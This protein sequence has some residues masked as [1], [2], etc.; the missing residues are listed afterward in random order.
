MSLR[1]RFV[2]GLVGI[3]MAWAV[4]AEALAAMQRI[5]LSP[6]RYSVSRGQPIRVPGRCLDLSRP[7]PQFHHT[8][9]GG[10][11]SISVTRT[12]NGR[13][14]TK[15]L[16]E[17]NSKWVRV[18]GDGT[19]GGVRFEPLDHADYR[20]DVGKISIVG[21]N[22]EDVS[23]AHAA[24]NKNQNALAAIDQLNTFESRLEATF[25]R[26]SGLSHWFNASRAGAEWKLLDFERGGKNELDA[27]FDSFGEQLTRKT[28]AESL[29]ALTL[30]HG[31]LLSN[32][33]IVVARQLF[34]IDL[35]SR[36]ANDFTNQF[37]RYA[38][39]RKS[40]IDTFGSRGQELAATYARAVQERLQGIPSANDAA[41]MLTRLSD[42]MKPLV[43]TAGVDHPLTRA[44]FGRL[45]QYVAVTRGDTARALART[46]ED[47]VP[48]GI[49]TVP[50]A[51]EY[52]S[53]RN[54]MPLD[55]RA[56]QALSELAGVKIDSADGSLKNAILIT[57]TGVRTTSSSEQ[58]RIASLPEAELKRLTEGKRV[59]IDAEPVDYETPVALKFAGIE[60]E[61]FRALETK[62]RRAA[63]VKDV[64]NPS[65]SQQSTQL[66]HALAS[67]RA[68]EQ[69]STRF[70]NLQGTGDAILLECPG[71][72]RTFALIDTGLSEVGYQSI[73]RQLPQDGNVVLKV[74]IT[75]Q[76]ADHL[77]GLKRFLQDS[78]RIN[79]TQVIVGTFH[80]PTRLY[81]DVLQLLNRGSF[82]ARRIEN[83]N[84]IGFFMR[85]T[86]AQDV[87]KMNPVPLNRSA[88][89]LF[90]LSP[91]GTDMKVQIV[92]H[93]SPKNT[94][95]SALLTR[96]EHRGKTEL[97]TSDIDFA[98]IR[99]LLNEGSEF[100]AKFSLQSDIL[101]WPHHISFPANMTPRDKAALAEFIRTVN[102]HTIIFSNR[103]AMQTDEA[104]R[105]A[106]EFIEQRFPHIQTLW[107]VSDGTVELI[108]RNC[109]RC[110]RDAG[111]TASKQCRHILPA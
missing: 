13:S 77:Q 35:P 98:V 24:L 72:V 19:D 108:T 46:R 62:A 4:P 87:I 7:A 27:L 103:G 76:D 91:L 100:R 79:V 17:V 53:L 44:F 90:T 61:P 59:F 15:P 99:D 106:V 45:N 49:T 58:I 32:S 78:G 85:D 64:I 95:Q 71:Q 73:L 25:G 16:N 48:P 29:Q 14:E 50:H 42:G 105:S 69:L 111:E 93:Q 2:L 22:A 80:E 55:D 10:G 63:L 41:T 81:N 101:K 33:Q 84:T 83:A 51:A 30:L 110:T 97:L 43:T 21:E 40:L 109:S 74:I 23:R 57:S 104:Y 1:N 67:P 34:S 36:Y 37:P 11:D 92:Q 38:D 18:T 12:F 75:H 102:P 66:K 28:P 65:S 3:L 52:L 68:A 9:H 88:F 82:I 96:I 70:V 47:M 60:A 107:T 8:L 31:H 6:G 5:R 89:Q 26:D 56:M 39:A 86:A 54:G 94:N 20:I